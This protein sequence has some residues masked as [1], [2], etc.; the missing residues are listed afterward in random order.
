[1]IKYEHDTCRIGLVLK[2]FIPLLQEQKRYVTAPT[3][4]RHVAEFKTW[5]CRVASLCLSGYFSPTNPG[6]FGEETK[7]PIIP[8]VV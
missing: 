3:E 6:P 1:M 8:K 7:N 5:N 2:G 4:L